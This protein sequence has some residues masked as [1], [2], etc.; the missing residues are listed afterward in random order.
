MAVAAYF[1]KEKIIKIIILAQFILTYRP[2]LH[3]AIR[4]FKKTKIFP[5]KFIE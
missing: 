5:T 2:V 1:T 4:P 3:T